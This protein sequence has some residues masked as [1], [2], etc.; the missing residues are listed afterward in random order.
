MKKQRIWIVLTV[1]VLAALAC[2][3]PG[4]A[5][6]VPAAPNLPPPTPIVNA[7]PVNVDAAG[8]QEALVS[9][10]ERV[11]P[12]I[13]SL[14]VLG[15]GGGSQG[16]GSVYDDQGHIITNFH[17]VEGA[18]RLKWTSQPVTKSTGR[19]SVRTWTPTWPSLK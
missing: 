3:V 11:M 5:P 9:L 10:Y 1:L 19:S 8:Q 14:K 16:S 2:Q 15:D 12:G 4:T 6:A 7:V 17:V 18:R 13:V